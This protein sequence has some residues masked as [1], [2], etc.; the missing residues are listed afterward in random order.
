MTSVSRVFSITSA[1]GS[2]HGP[3][4]DP[5][6]PPPAATHVPPTHS[7]SPQQSAPSAV[8]HACPT[9]PQHNCPNDGVSHVK[10]RPHALLSPHCSA[11]PLHCIACGDTHAPFTHSRSPQQSE[12]S[13]VPHAWPSS[14]QHTCPNDVFPHESPS[15]QP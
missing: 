9:S 11:A 6:P 14:P 5:P 13:A 7:S 2:M 3:S 4:H 1:G 12:P 15:Q 10:S 8:P